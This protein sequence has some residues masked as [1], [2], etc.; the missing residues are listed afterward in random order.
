VT[1]G[2]PRRTQKRGEL[3]YLFLQPADANHVALFDMPYS[4]RRDR[5]RGKVQ[6]AT[7]EGSSWDRVNTASKDQKELAQRT[8]SASEP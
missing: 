2:E 1:K 7:Q 8:T 5:Q 6:K 4:E 3:V